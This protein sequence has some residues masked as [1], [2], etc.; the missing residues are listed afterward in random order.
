VLPNDVVV[1]G[2]FDL[3]STD[4]AIWDSF[5]APLRQAL[6]YPVTLKAAV[7]AGSGRG[8]S[9]EVT[10]LFAFYPSDKVPDVPLRFEYWIDSL[11]QSIRI[12]PPPARAA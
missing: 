9:P 10:Y 4:S 8:G 11:Q 12:E 6:A 1:R 2:L 7:G 5:D 3:Q